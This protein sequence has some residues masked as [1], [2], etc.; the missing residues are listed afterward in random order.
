MTPKL[1]RAV[2]AVGQL[3]R[4]RQDELADA[5]LEAATRAMIDDSI[6]AGEASLAKHGGQSPAEVFDRLLAKYDA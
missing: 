5:I 3:P 4:A 2:E 1:T 6:A